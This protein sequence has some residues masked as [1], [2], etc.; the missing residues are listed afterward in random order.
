MRR[1]FTPQ[2]DRIHPTPIEVQ[3]LIIRPGDDILVV[4]GGQTVGH[5]YAG[6]S[7]GTYWTEAPL[8]TAEGY[9]PGPYRLEDFRHP[10]ILGGM[11]KAID[12]SK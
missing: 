8:T 1:T 11:A 6:E 4:A 9:G 7:G 12:E 10:D 5:V 3:G 2:G